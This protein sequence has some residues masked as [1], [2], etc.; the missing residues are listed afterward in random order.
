VRTDVISV[1]P[2]A[3]PPDDDPDFLVRP[4]A[5]HADDARRFTAL[6]TEQHSLVRNFARRR[7]GEDLAQEIVAETFLVAWRRIDDVPVSPTP[8]LY[9]IALYEIANLRRR[10][11]KAFRLRDALQEHHVSL[12]RQGESHEATDLAD[13]VAVAF[14]TLKPRD[15]EI[16]RLAAW[17]QLSAVEGAAVL[18]C[19]ISAYRMRLHRARMRLAATSDVRGLVESQ[20]GQVSEG[21][22]TPTVFSRIAS[23]GRRPLEGTELVL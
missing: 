19:S 15:Q 21:P 16:L 8:W 20:P 2:G 7:V 3:R 18:Q 9:R 4:G 10:Q 23:L 13:A 5:E 11:A 22:E 6:Y 1:M 14:E 17:D 12:S